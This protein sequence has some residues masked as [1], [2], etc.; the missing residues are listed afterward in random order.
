MAI[1]PVQL[2]V[3]GFSQPDFHGEIIEEL[4]RLR[5]SDTVR[6]IDALAVHKDAAG[7]IEVLH[8]SNLSKD[9]AIELV[10]VG[11]PTW[12]LTTSM[13]IRSFLRSE[14]AGRLLA[15]T[16]F[17][18]F[19]ACRRYWRGN[20]KSMRK[21]GTERGGEFV[22]GTHFAAAGGQVHSLLSLVSDLATGENRPRYLG[23]RI[24]PAGI[25]PDYRG[26]AQTFANALVDSAQPELDTGVST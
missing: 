6:V 15:G 10:C 17:A 14:A 12:W 21:L 13:P 4:E 16:R 2:I 26:E 20:L 5:E 7:E 3:L 23:L 9:E 25:T 24:P 1:G 18:A 11:S 19:V 22:D 8:L